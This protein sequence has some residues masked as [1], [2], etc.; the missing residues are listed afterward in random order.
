MSGTNIFQARD[1][2][3]KP[4]G[5]ASTI[6][7]PSGSLF[8]FFILPQTSLH[9]AACKLYH[10]SSDMTAENVRHKLIS[11][12]VPRHKKKYKC[13]VIQHPLGCREIL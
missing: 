4:D 8:S 9:D 1:S 5:S 13:Q 12:P 11:G 2:L 6:R 3:R 7:L 10:V